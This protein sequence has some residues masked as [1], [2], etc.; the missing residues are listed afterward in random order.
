VR[1]VKTARKILI[2]T[3]I[4]C[5]IFLIGGMAYSL[6]SSGEE[7]KTVAPKKVDQGQDATIR[8]IKPHKPN[9]NSPASVALYML[10]E[11]APAGSN[12]GASVKTVPT[13]ACTISVTYNDGP[14]QDSGLVS[15]TAD[16]FGVVGWTWTVPPATPEGKYPVKVTCVYNG[17]S[18]VGIQDLVVTR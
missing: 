14:S 9:P 13:A 11:S 2:P 15:K 3:A 6:L 17:R 16:D 4:L 7:V 18:A 1:Y 10:Q 5:A 8:D 12:A